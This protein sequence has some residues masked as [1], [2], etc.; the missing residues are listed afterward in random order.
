MA[1]R[2]AIVGRPNVGKSTLFNRLAGRRLALVDDAPGVTRDRR[3]GAGRIGKL[4]LEL[5]DTAGVDDPRAKGLV[6]RMRA[7]TEA[8]ARG[9][10]AVIFMVDAREGVTGLD[11]DVARWLRR[12]GRPVVLAANKCEGAAAQAGLGEAHALGFGPPIALSA[13]H[14]QGLSE[15]AAALGAHA[16][17][18]EPA[19]PEPPA[20]AG[21]D[22]DR[23]L[24]LAVVGRPNVGK[25]TLVNRLVG[26]ERLLTGPEP[27][28]TRDAIEVGWRWRGKRFALVD[29]AGLRRKARIDERLEKLSVGDTLRAVKESHVVVLVLDAALGLE[30]Q[31]LQIARLA[32]E[33]G[34]ALVIAVNKWDLVDE[35]AKAQRALKDRLEISLPQVRGVRVVT[36]SALHARKLD[37]LLEAAVAARE[38]WNAELP[39]RKLN[40]WLERVEAGHPPPLVKG[41]RPRLLFC[42]QVARRPPTIAIFGRQL[43]TL[44]DEYLRYLANSLR[45]EFELPG[46]VIRFQLRQ[47]ENPYVGDR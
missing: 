12:L 47:S 46:T 40:R 34:R 42:R 26:E 10:D 17:P 30:K 27:G 22:A 5:V 36:V 28:I 23:V 3:E 2:V 37:A 16:P 41:R 21:D 7:Q 35:P 44:P 13:E 32:V 29:T 9:A 33:E 39:T 20:E 43:T 6:D 45:D 38:S 4:A 8:A 11:R 19:A 14:G 1:F 18:A 31:D 24:R 15:L 25:S